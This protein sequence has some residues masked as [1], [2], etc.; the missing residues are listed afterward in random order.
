MVNGMQTVCHILYEISP[1]MRT[2]Y[3][4]LIIQQL[5]LAF[6]ANGAVSRQ[7]RNFL[8][9]PECDVQNTLATHL[10]I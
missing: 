3:T 1:R 10:R 9:F 6:H 8:F 4:S 7:Q 5:S 2:L